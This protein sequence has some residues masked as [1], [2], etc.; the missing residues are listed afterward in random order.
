M[1]YGNEEPATARNIE[2]SSRLCWLTVIRK[3]EDFCKSARSICSQVCQKKLVIFEKICTEGVE[4]L[5]LE[6]QHCNK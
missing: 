5:I 4:N 2:A 1:H 6:R 3:G